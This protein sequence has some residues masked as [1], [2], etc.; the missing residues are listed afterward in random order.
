MKK[1]SV[2]IIILLLVLNNASAKL[3]NGYEKDIHYVREKLKNYSD[4]MSFNNDLS[5]SDKRNMKVAIKNL[6]A[7]QS[8]YELTEELLNRFKLI[9]PNLYH[10]IDSIKDAKGRPTDVYVKFIPREEALEMEGGITYVA[11]SGDDKDVCFSEYGRLSVSIKIWAFSEALRALSHEFG[12]V[13][14]QVPNHGTYTQYYKSVYRPFSSESNH[15]G[16][17]GT[18]RSGRNADIFEKEFKR[19]YI[20]YLK[21][22]NYAPL[23]SPQVLVG[24]IK[25]KV[26]SHIA[27]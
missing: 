16:H 14:Y 21:V 7:F 17:A 24:E 1:Y 12:H 9:S 11:Q 25:K 18:D 13:N 27:M 20:K 5:A 6:I 22:N 23:A 19:D 3:K 4:S 15:L 26:K 8:Y 10:R 2:I